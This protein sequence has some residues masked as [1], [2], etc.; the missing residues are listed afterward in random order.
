MSNHA[1][2]PGFSMWPVPEPSGVHNKPTPIQ[3]KL[4]PGKPAIRYKRHLPR[5]AISGAMMW[6][7]GAGV[8][9]VGFYFV[10]DGRK[11]RARLAAEKTESRAAILPCLQAEEDRRQVRVQYQGLKAETMIMSDVKTWTPG[12]SVYN[13]DRHVP[14]T[15]TVKLGNKM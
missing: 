3:D 2:H 13:T 4:S 11:Q 7:G 6:A 1:K 10:I 5:G 12:A 8:M 9:A 14:P 15:P